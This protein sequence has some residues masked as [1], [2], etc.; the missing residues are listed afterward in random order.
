MTF[1][2]LGDLGQALKLGAHHR[3]A[4]QWP[5]QHCLVHHRPHLRR[6]RVR[7]HVLPLEPHA[8]PAVDL[9]GRRRL[10]A[11]QGDGAGIALGLEQAVHEL[12]LEAADDRSGPFQ[13]H[14]S[15]KPVGQ[16]VIVFR[17]PARAVGLPGQGQHPGPCL[18]VGYPVEGEQV[19][20]IPVLKTDPAILHP[21]DLGAGRPDL[22]SR[23]VRRHSGGLAK[24]AQLAPDHY[25]QRSRARWLIIATGQRTVTWRNH[26]HPSS[27]T[28]H[29]SAQRL[30]TRD[31]YGIRHAGVSTRPN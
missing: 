22:I 4:A 13:A 11:E 21:A 15:L 23:L 12:Q 2:K 19:G 18:L 20:D 1:G 27:R 31:T 25:A 9:L 5:P 30:P 29:V 7:E 26:A 16:D 6:L 14:V 3:A 10:V 28:R 24:A 8:H 17:P